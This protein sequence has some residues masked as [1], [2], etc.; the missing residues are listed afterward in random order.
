MIRPFALFVTVLFS[1]TPLCAAVSPEPTAAAFMHDTVATYR[2]MSS[3]QDR[4]RSVQTLTSYPGD[5]DPSNVE[6]EFV[7]LFK[8][9]NKFKFSSTTT[10]NFGDGPDV[11]HDAIWSDGSSVWEWSSG[12]IVPKSVEGF[13]MAVAEV[14]GVSHGMAHE[15]FRLLTDEVTGFRFDQLK[16]LKI[17]R[18]DKLAGVDC[19]VVHGLQFDHEVDLWIGKGDHLIRKGIETAPDTSTNTFERRDIVVDGEIPE[20]AFTLRSEPN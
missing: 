7:T 5:D 11:S 2:A 13:G 8:R 3:Y 6:I 10:D 4:G 20:T 15:I 14:T 9:P 1:S 16:Q 12:D 18:S 19:Y 17:L